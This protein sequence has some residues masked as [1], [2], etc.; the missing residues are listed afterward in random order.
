[1][2]NFGECIVID[3]LQDKKEWKSCLR[4]CN[5]WT[6]KTDE[7]GLFEHHVYWTS[8]VVRHIH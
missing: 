7:D 3:E 6:D 1:M 2:K 4:K 5:W 8:S